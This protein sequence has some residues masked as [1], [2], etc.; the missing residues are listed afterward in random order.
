MLPS[1]MAGLNEADMQAVLNTYTFSNW[2]FPT[3]FP[4]KEQYTFDFKAIEQSMTLRVAADVVARGASIDKKSRPAVGKIFGELPKLAIKRTMDENEIDEYY[5]MLDRTSGDA[6]ARKIVE[7]WSNDTQFCF[8]G[9]GNKLEIIGLQGF[10]RGKVNFTG[11]TNQGIVTEFALDYKCPNQVGVLSGSAAWSDSEA[12]KPIDDLRLRVQYM[13]KQK[14]ISPKFAFMNIDTF[15]LMAATKQVIERC[16]SFA[17]NALGIQ[18]VPGI[19]EV[20]TML[21]KIPD[22]YGLQIVIIDVDPI[23][24]EIDGEYHSIKPFADNSVILTESKQVGQTFWK[25]PNDRKVKTNATFAQRQYALVKKF[26]YDEP[27]E[28]VT[29]GIANALPVWEGA[30]R[31]LMMDVSNTEWSIQ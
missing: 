29:M 22:L 5:T 18:G 1:I 9:L 6:R 3:M 8:D 17:A 20:N 13:R 27:L 28:E 4:L 26:A 15:V 10:S 16:A 14:H 25:A 23:D 24:A 11:E 12:A 2:Y 30:N 7:Y 21:A 31:S 19:T